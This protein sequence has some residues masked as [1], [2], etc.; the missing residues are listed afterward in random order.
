MG[1]RLRGNDRSVYPM[2]MKDISGIL[3]ALGFTDSE[4]RIYLTAL[5]AGPSTVIDLAALT[6][7]SRQ[8]VYVAIESLLERELITSSQ[9]DKR[10]L[11][12]AEHPEKLH[13]YA[14]RR[15]LEFKRHVADLEEVVPELELSVHGEKPI[16][17]LFEGKEGIRT[18]LHDI[19]TSQE[20]RFIEIADLRAMADI[21]SVDENRAMM[22]E[23]ATMECTFQCLYAGASFGDKVFAERLSLPIE[24]HD[25]KSSMTI[26]G[27]KIAFVTFEGTLP[28]LLIE[29][30]P[31]AKLLRVLFALAFAKV[32]GT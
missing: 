3:Q 29:S 16:V 31:L 9:Q 6:N 27:N 7:L 21:F 4:S 22:E 23:I 11:F 18:I 10:N 14:K 26:Y 2:R 19:F 25:F 12:I 15:E 32:Q 24:H 17:K 8:A 30:A 5:Q 28:S 13:A 20:K 1:S